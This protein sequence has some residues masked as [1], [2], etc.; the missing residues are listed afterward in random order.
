MRQM[1]ASLASPCRLVPTRRSVGP[2]IPHQ[3]PCLLVDEV[4]LLGRQLPHVQTGK[5]GLW[6]W[7]YHHGWGHGGQA[8][9]QGRLAPWPS[10]QPPAHCALQ[11]GP[12]LL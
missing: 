12:S 5:H 8:G 7:W 6:L 10:S 1:R 11:A 9:S 3:D 4:L 2:T